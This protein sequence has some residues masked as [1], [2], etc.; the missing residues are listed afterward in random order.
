MD[1]EQLRAIQAPLK[2]QYR[3]AP[4]LARTTMAATGTILPEQLACRVET[5]SGPVIAG[6]HPAAGGDG[7]QACSGDM[8]LQSLVACSGVTLAA[9]ATALSIPIQS[10]KIYADA[11]LD[12]R[13]TLGIEKT[14][15]V[16][17][18]AIRV[19]FELQSTASHEQLDKLIVLVERYCVVLQTLKGAAVVEATWRDSAVAP[20]PGEFS[21]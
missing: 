6:L 17:I 14:C 18:T 10:A 5:Q 8:L 1:A 2:Q 16:G 7:S 13:G 20:I 11:E 19:V 15:P 9:V 21:D 3:D 12:F 4:H